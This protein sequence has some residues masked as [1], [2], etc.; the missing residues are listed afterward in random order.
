MLTNLIKSPVF[1]YKSN[2]TL[3]N[4]LTEK[5]PFIEHGIIGKSLCRRDIDYLSIGNP[6]DAVLFVGGTHGLEWLTSLVLLLFL[7]KISEAYSTNGEIAGIKIK[8]YLGKRGLVIIP[9]LNPDGIEISL[10]GAKAACAYKN[11]VND[12]SHGDTSSWQ[13]NA[14]GV[15]LNHNFDAGWEALSKLEKSQGIAGPAPTRYG[16][17]YPLSEPETQELISFFINNNFRHVLAFHS[18]GEEIYWDFGENTPYGSDFIAKIMEA[19]SGYK[20]AKPEGLAVGGGLKDMIIEKFGKPAF[21]IEIGKGKNP[22]PI[23]DLFDIYNKIEEMLVFA[24]VV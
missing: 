8:P 18:Q 19:S 12:V 5:Y 7:E 13:A 23:D 24:T 16:G 14:R 9:M 20:M 4:A 22:L 21:T 6:D 15:D 1:D 10:H 11:L 17:P 3:I 2:K